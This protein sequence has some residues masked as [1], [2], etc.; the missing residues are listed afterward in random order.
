MLLHWLIS[1]TLAQAPDPQ[2][3]AETEGWSIARHSGGCVMTREFGGDGNM[4]VSFAVDPGDDTSPLTILVGNSGWSL[5]DADDD[6][7]QIEFS[8]SDA[9]WD[10]LAARTF[11]TDDSGDSDPD[12]VISIGFAQDAI[13][14]MLEDVAAA[15]GLHLL[16]QGVTVGRVSFGGSRAAVGSLGECVS[17][18]PDSAGPMLDSQSGIR[19][20]PLDED[21]SGMPAT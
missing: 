10:D 3:F 9:V 1:A 18:L 5:P 17:T 7:Y 11:T 21:R 20:A 4:M 14:L 13:A 12:G 8:G 6:G 16:R 15:D 2:M 19:H